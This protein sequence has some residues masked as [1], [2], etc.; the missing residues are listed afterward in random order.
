VD[1]HAAVGGPQEAVL[2]PV[3]LAGAQDEAGGLERRDV[4]GLRA[5]VRDR[6]HDVDVGLGRHPGHG[7]RADVLEDDDAVAECLADGC[8]RLVVALGPG[9]VVLGERDR[10]VVARA[11]AEQLHPGLLDEL[12]AVAPRVVDVEALHVRDRVVPAHLAAGPDEPFGQGRERAARDREG[13]VRLAR[14]REVLGHADVQRLSGAEREPHAAAVAQRRG[15]RQLGQV[16]HAAVEAPGVGLAARRRGDL[17]MVEPHDRHR[18][19]VPPRARGTIRQ[20]GPVSAGGGSCVASSRRA[21]KAGSSAS[22]S[23]AKTGRAR[24]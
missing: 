24:A 10:G 20:P 11:R 23:P 13:R 9:G 15:L 7:R 14:R 8:R 6:E 4:V 19:T 12:E 22:Y 1:L 5:R 3:G 21:R 18:P 17:H 2:E 16:E